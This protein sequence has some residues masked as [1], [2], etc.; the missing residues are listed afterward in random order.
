MG[1]DEQILQEEAIT[2]ATLKFAERMCERYKIISVQEHGRIYLYSDGV[3]KPIMSP[4]VT[5]DIENMIINMPGGRSLSTHKRKNVIH[6]ISTIAYK[7]LDEINP[8]GLINFENGVF[9]IFSKEF[10]PHSPDIVF[11]VKI[12][13]KYNPEARSDAWEKYLEE[14]LDGDLNKILPLQEFCGYCF[15]KTCKFERALFLSGG[16][17]AGKSTFTET[18]RR[19]IGRENCS[20]TSLSH[21]SDPVLRCSIRDK[22][23]NFDSDLPERAAEYEEIFKKISSGEPIKFNEKFLPSIDEEV[24]CKMVFNAN[25]FPYINDSTSAFY[26]R[27]ILVKFDKEF[28]DDTA[29]VDLKSRLSEP[30][31]LSGIFNWCMDGLDRLIKNN[32]FSNNIEMKNHIFEIR[33]ENNPILQFIEDRIIFKEGMCV[34]KRNTWEI[35]K[36]WSADSGHKH[37]LTFRKFCRKFIEETRKHGVKETQRTV[38]SRD[39]AWQNIDIES[40]DSLTKWTVPGYEN[41]P[42]ETIDWDV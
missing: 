35:Y 37:F 39:K 6:N 36:E 4:R 19:I 18:L 42:T 38:G 41:N 17:G 2:E 25:D 29:D 12:P 23:V 30:E 9:N 32:K 5:G 33:K 15:M 24:R 14:T 26:R 31:N 10:L 28:N 1:Y 21:L 27:M 34:P 3:Y 20:A 11:T 16:G 7:P 40:I 13:Y 22:Y 8:E